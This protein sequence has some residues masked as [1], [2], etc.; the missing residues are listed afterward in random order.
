MHAYAPSGAVVELQELPTAC[1]QLLVG[2]VVDNFPDGSQ[3]G[4]R[5]SNRF[6]LQGSL[7]EVC[8][9]NAGLHAFIRS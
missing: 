4:V 1:W 8:Q 7:R 2:N 5:L 6:R 3:L 9:A